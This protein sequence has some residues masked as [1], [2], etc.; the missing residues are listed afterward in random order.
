MGECGPHTF[1]W[2]LFCKLELTGSFTSMSKISLELWA[3]T[4]GCWIFT[5]TVLPSWSTALCTWASDAAPKGVSSKLVKSSFICREKRKRQELGVTRGYS[6][7]SPA[8]RPESSCTKAGPTQPFHPSVPPLALSVF[9][10]WVK[11][12]KHKSA[13]ETLCLRKPGAEPQHHVSSSCSGQAVCK[14]LLQAVLKMV[15]SDYGQHPGCR[16][17]QLF[18]CTY[19]FYRYLIPPTITPET[20][21]CVFLCITAAAASL[22]G[23]SQHMTGSS[24]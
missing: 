14:R 23:E 3:W 21:L 11:P 13:L 9:G 7:E 24:G 2:Q 12:A 4:L 19:L 10:L 18:L 8:H 22:L 5:A 20:W 1:Q 17:Q 15:W 16:S 6:Q